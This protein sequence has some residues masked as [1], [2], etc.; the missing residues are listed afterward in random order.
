[1]TAGDCMVF[2]YKEMSSQNQHFRLVAV[3]SLVLLGVGV[4][5]LAIN[6]YGLSQPLRKPGL[7]VTDPDQLRFIPEQVWAYEHSVKALHSLDRELPTEEVAQLL[8]LMV[9]MS[10]VHIDWKRV[11]P[12]EYRQ[13]IPIWE[14]YFLYLIGR[15]SNLPQFERYHFVNYKRSLERGIGICGDAS[16]ILSSVLNLYDIKNRIISFDGHVIV[17]YYD[18]HGKG[19]LLD[20]DFG[21]SIDVPLEA[22]ANDLDSVK[23]LYLDSGYTENEIDYL[24]DAYSGGY[25]SFD[26]VFDFMSKRYI[27]EYL[28]YAMKWALPVFFIVLSFRLSRRRKVRSRP[29]DEL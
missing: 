25:R 7:G 27:F 6:V 20:P 28:S 11:D 17:E 21:V 23:S 22:F 8:N 2:R 29:M 13:L 9:N 10:I 15:Y 4:L 18:S 5:L 1:M 12:V 14:N 3:F 16:I 26:G 24:L 19:R